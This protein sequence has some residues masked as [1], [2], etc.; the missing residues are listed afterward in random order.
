MSQ[1][2]LYPAPAWSPATALA[3]DIGAGDLEITVD[4]PGD[5][6]TLPN[7]LVLTS[8]EGATAG[9]TVLAASVTGVTVTLTS[10]GASAQAWPAGT[11]VWR[12]HVAED[13]NAAKTC[14]EDHETRLAFVEQGWVEPDTN[15][16]LQP[17]LPRSWLE[18]DAN[19]DVQPAIEAANDPEFELDTQGNI[20]PMV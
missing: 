14:I 4:A 8:S 2:P 13:H 6:P 9:E 7:Y 1:V 10:R 15:G 5:L 18:L 12:P 17:G 20:Q 11:V 16:D 19:G 3:A